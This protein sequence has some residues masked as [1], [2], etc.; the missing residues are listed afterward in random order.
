[1]LVFVNANTALWFIIAALAVNGLGIGIFASPNTNA[2]MGSVEKKYLG[3]AAGTVGTMRTAGMMI[4]MGIMMILFSLFIGQ[5]EITPPYHPEFLMSART[6]FII[7]TV[8]SIFGLLC[9]MI[10]R[11]YRKHSGSG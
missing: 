5:A 3:V 10:A 7:F 8:V 4:S 9:Q 6:G 1:M 2:I 11:S